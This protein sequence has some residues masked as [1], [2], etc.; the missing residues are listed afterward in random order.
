MKATK[1][2][3]RVRFET[4]IQNDE[5]FQKSHA[6]TIDTHKKEK[7]KKTLIIH[8]RHERRLD[9]LKGDMHQIYDSIFHGIPVMDIKPILGHKNNRP[10]KRDLTQARP[11]T[12]LLNSVKKSSENRI[13]CGTFKAPTG[14]EKRFL[15]ILE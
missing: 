4:E 2:A 11:N 12:K 7:C 3:Q 6:T 15:F 10:V 1:N 14:I 13:L 9:A 5:Q 8:C